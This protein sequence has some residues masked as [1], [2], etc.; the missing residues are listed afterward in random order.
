MGFSI[1]NGENNKKN[2]GF[3][4]QFSSNGRFSGESRKKREIAV[5]VPKFSTSKRGVFSYIQ[6]EQKIILSYLL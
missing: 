4:L 1:A 3:C 6:K 5:I 2:K